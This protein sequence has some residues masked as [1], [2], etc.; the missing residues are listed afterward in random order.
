MARSTFFILEE[1]QELEFGEKDKR[2]RKGVRKM[3]YFGRFVANYSK[4]RGGTEV[5]DIQ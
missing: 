4:V 3:Q 2:G 5:A 1:A